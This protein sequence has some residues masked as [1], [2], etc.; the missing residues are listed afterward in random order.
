MIIVWDNVSIFLNL[1]M[2]FL[3]TD[4]S[5]KLRIWQGTMKKQ[6]HLKLSSADWR[7]F[8]SG[9]NVFRPQYIQQHLQR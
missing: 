5:F 2:M 6:M 9:H 7:P 4:F 3:F 8:Y 1:F